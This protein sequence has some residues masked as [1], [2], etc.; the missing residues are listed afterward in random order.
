MARVTR[1]M[2]HRWCSAAAARDSA[3]LAIAVILSFAWYAPHLG[4][5]SD[6]WAFIGRYAT[7]ADQSVV[8]F[9]NAS[10]SPQHASRPMQLWLCAALYA[11]FGMD[12]LAYHG[13]NGV[14]LV[15]NALLCYA[16]AR[17]LRVS[18]TI[19]LSVALIYGLLPSYSTDRL[20]YV[21]FA[22][23]LSMTACLAS[24]YADLEAAG[25]RVSSGIVWKAI[26]ATSLLVSGLSYEVAIPV[27]VVTPFLMIWRT[28]KDNQHIPR[29]RMIYLA[30]LI[31]INV[32]LVAG[33]TAFKLRTTVRLGARA[34]LVDQIT[35]IAR[36]AVRPDVPAG[37]YGL[38]LFS[39]V[40]VHFG[41]YGLNL[42][43]TALTLARGAPFAVLSLTVAFAFAVF[44]YLASAVREQQWP[45]FREWSA[46]IAGGVVV[47]G[48][49]YAIFLTNYNVQF[50]PTG[51]ANRSAIAAA[52]GAA[53][54]IVG[55]IGWLVTPLSTT[56]FGPIVFASLIAVFASS[57]FLVI[58]IVAE[59]WVVAF[60]TE[61]AVLA[62]IQQRFP[63]LRHS[64]T[65]ILDGVC[66]YIGPA[67]VFES[68]WD[69]AG[70]LQ[71]IYRDETLK[72]DVATPRL[73]VRD[74]AITTTIYG[75]VTTYP[76]GRDLFVFDARSGRVQPLPDAATARA[77]FARSTSGQS[78]APGREGIGVELF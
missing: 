59:R 73:A 38:N 17:R 25:A 2:N 72:A 29:Q 31:A 65:L 61:R 50:T 35:A 9:F 46:L 77:Y 51:I 33:I 16:I 32:V 18:R 22:I 41:D 36:H 68:N 62:A 21:A 56:K 58:N 10:H 30:V 6:D 12:P 44:W 42:P 26:A 8:G 40:R 71:T 14:L 13:F 45:A 20:W 53:M 15:L 1:M 49:G 24:I 7:A 37:E 3:F 76:Y 74:D 4:F 11:L 52:L 55:A 75:Q 48:L 34:G 78:C 60:A 69:L 70:A 28:W 19:A 5:Y 27:F 47:F 63:T 43:R 67:I 64:S 39:A 23:T 66:P 54:C 57:G